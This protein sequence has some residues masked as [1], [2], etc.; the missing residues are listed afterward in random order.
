[1]SPIDHILQFFA[2]GHL[3]ED[4]HEVSSKCAELANYMSEKLP[5]NPETTAGLRKLLEAKDCFVRSVMVKDK[6]T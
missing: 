5:S 1:M 4:M 3:R 2:Y 6:A